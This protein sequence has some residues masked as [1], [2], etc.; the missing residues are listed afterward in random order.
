MGG[1]RLPDHVAAAARTRRHIDAGEREE[2]LLPRWVGLV[3]PGRFLLHLQVSASL[4][5]LGSDVAAGKKTVVADLDEAI[6]EHMEEKTPDELLRR[7][8]GLRQEL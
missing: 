4:F 2:P 6:G 7:N 8:G 5:E 1:E 3:L